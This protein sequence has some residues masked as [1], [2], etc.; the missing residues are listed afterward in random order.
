MS[1]VSNKL[2]YKEWSRLDN[3]SEGTMFCVRL[4]Y[5]PESAELLCPLGGTEWSTWQISLQSYY[6]ELSMELKAMLQ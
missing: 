2:G 1:E 6:W 5:L 3:K 4:Q